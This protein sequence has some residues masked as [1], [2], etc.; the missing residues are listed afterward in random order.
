MKPAYV[1]KNNP[2]LDWQERKLFTEVSGEMEQMHLE[3]IEARRPI[4]YPF[5][6]I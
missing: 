5:K 1:I 3:M 2:E 6:I 4:H